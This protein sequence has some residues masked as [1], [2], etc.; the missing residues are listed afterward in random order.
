VFGAGIYGERHWLERATYTVHFCERCRLVSQRDVPYE[1]LLHRLQELRRLNVSADPSRNQITQEYATKRSAA[2][3]LAAA[4][5]HLDVTPLR[6]LSFEFSSRESVQTAKPS[7][8]PM[9]PT[10]ASLRSGEHPQTSGDQSVGIDDGPNGTFD[11]IHVCHA[12]ECSSDPRRIAMSLARKLRAG[13]VLHIAVRNGARIRRKL[14]RFE[15]DLAKSQGR[16]L[17]TPVP[18]QALNCFCSETLM[19]LAAEC[20]LERLRPGWRS[21]FRAYRANRSDSDTLLPTLAHLCYLRSRHSTDLSF[22]KLP[23]ID[24]ENCHGAIT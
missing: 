4:M 23:T 24:G 18:L 8:A 17:H 16:I 6:T 3:F 5:A 15:C 10:A 12:L 1:F 11:V 21:L 7:G 9:K 22:R 20:G 14:H 19:F 2:I 13:G